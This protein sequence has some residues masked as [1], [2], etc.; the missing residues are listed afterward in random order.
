MTKNLFDL[1]GKTALVTGSTRGLG[2]AYARALADA[3]AKVVLNGTKPETLDAAVAEL[4]GDGID[5]DGIS[6]DVGDEAAVIAGFEE[7]DRRGIV[8]DIVVNNAGIQHRQPMLELSTA[9]WKRVVDVHLTG[10][11]VVAR[12]AVK[13]LMAKGR[14]GKI[15]NIGSLT[16]EQARATVAPYTAAKG[17]IK[18]L[19]K[20]MTA[21]WAVHGIQANAI[22]PG[23]ILTEMTQ[24]LA[25]DPQFDGWVKSRIPSRRWGLPKDLAGTVVF[26]ASSASDY[27][28]GH[29]LYVDGGWL[30]VM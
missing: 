27:V 16:C 3:G 28:N 29:V 7:L 11:F 19:T 22:G 6:F 10:T 14:G 20:A 5:A 9:D 1:T 13:R 23:F 25:D 21:E 17:G 4:K 12:E 18:M 15:I 26:L 2:N 8:I 24:A 30:S